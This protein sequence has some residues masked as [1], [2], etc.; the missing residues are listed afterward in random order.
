MEKNT[1]TGRKGFRRYLPLVL[2]LGI[3]I[4]LIMAFRQ[5]LLPFV[6]AILVVYIIEPLVS[7]LNQHKFKGRLSGLTIPRWTC[8][9]IV[10]LVFAV[11]TSLFVLAIAPP[12]A[13][14]CDRLASEA[15][16]FM[17][18]LRD[19]HIPRWNSQINAFRERFFPDEMTEEHVEG[20]RYRV[21]D[22]FDNAESNALLFAAMRHEE[23]LTHMAGGDLIDVTTEPNETELSSPVRIRFNPAEEEWLVFIDEL[24]LVPDQAQAG[25][26]ILGTVE[27]RRDEAP[28]TDNGFDLERN[29]NNSLTELVEISGR[30]ITHLLTLGQELALALLSALLGIILTLLI[31][32]FISIDLAKILAFFRSLVPQKSLETYDELLK[33]LDSGLSGVIRAQL[34]ICMIYGVLTGLGLWVLGVKFALILG[35]LAGIL[36]IIPVFGTIISTI[37]AIAVAL[38]SQ[39]LSLAVMVTGWVLLLHFLVSDIVYPKLLSNTAKIHPVIVIFALLSGEHTFGL[40]GA[41]LAVPTASVVLTFIRFFVDRWRREARALG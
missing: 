41:L 3:S 28:D 7:G 9:I 16:R 29:I 23:R 24:E 15:P 8:V 11:F 5:V 27:E 12:L 31:A 20:V 36:S 4:L 10:Y 35:C 38:A 13:R 30:S 18:E 14:E 40:I 19:E 21:H 37:P 2:F 26:F 39:G 17:E 22:A 1:Q 25:R 33:Q 6:F 32:V 34:L